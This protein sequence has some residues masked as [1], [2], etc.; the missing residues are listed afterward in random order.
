MTRGPD[1]RMWVTDYEDTRSRCS[2]SP[3]RPHLDTTPV[4]RPR[5]RS[6]NGHG[7]NQ[8]NYPYNVDF[9]LDGDTVY[10]SDTGNGR[11]AALRHLRAGARCG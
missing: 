1:G 5:R 8:L 3:A 7:D 4:W 11:I 9:S 2:T 6:A 10:V